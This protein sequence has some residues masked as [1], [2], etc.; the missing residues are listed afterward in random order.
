M[1]ALK[2]RAL[3]VAGVVA[4]CS[5]SPIGGDAGVDGGADAGTAAD[6]AGPS[7]DGGLGWSPLARQHCRPD[8]GCP[9]ELEPLVLGRGPEA[10]TFSVASGALP[11]GL[12]LD[13]VTGVVSGSALAEGTFTAGV[14]VEDGVRAPAVTEVTWA[15][16]GTG[17]NAP[18]GLTASNLTSTGVRLTWSVT[19]VGAGVH[20]CRVLQDG[21]RVTYVEGAAVYDVTGLAPATAYDFAVR[22]YDF[23]QNAGAVSPTLTVTTLSASPG[24]GGVP[25]APF[26]PPAPQPFTQCTWFVGPMG[27]DGNSGDSTA[28]AWRTLGRANQAV[29]PGQSV[30]VRGGTYD[31]TIRPA[32]SGTAGQPITYAAYNLETVT[33]R[34]SAASAADLGGR[35]YVT[36]RQLRLNADKPGQNEPAVAASNSTGVQLLECE[37]VN[38]R[39]MLM[40]MA[41][42]WRNPWGV[43][44]ANASAFRIEG[45]RV[46]G[47]HQGVTISNSPRAVVRHNAIVDNMGNAVLSAEASGAVLGQLIEGNLLGGS[48]TSDGV[49]TDDYGASQQT[50][51]NVRGLVIRGNVIYFNAENG[52]DLKAAGDVV[53]EDNLIVAAMGDND[54][55]GF[56]PDDLWWLSR[57][58]TASVIHGSLRTA[59][60]VIIRRNVFYDGSGGVS[61]MKAGWHVFNNTFVNGNR[62]F[63]SANSTWVGE[64]PTF[65]ALVAPG[66]D[67]DFF[68]NVVMNHRHGAIWYWGGVAG[69]VW[70]HNVYFESQGAPRFIVRPPGADRSTAAQQFI[71]FAAFRAQLPAGFVGRDANS[72]IANPL[73]VNVPAQPVFPFA[74]PNPNAPVVAPRVDFA[75]ASTMFPHDFR[76][77]A[78][79]PA[80]DTGRHLTT[81]TNAATGGTSLRVE[82]SGYFFAGYGVV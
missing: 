45:C 21:V 65:T 78:A 40:T 18:S 52:I 75:N 30:C 39:P 63:T 7:A 61:Q 9:L 73:F 55:H 56:R 25:S 59:G 14:H 26:G 76:L 11:V 77:Q 34:G 35:Q 22:C 5:A 23:A 50:A 1:R 37:V 67:S 64:E 28:A 57:S 20:G 27:D 29:Q 17:P 51:I 4:A 80:A 8:A 32:A 46:S 41:D 15:I 54:G 12:A 47:W 24:D 43:I 19:D 62:D 13:G 2:A 72:R 82:R 69:T 58:A 36:L 48:L 16:D 10:L 49:Q 74:Q 31:E 33:V 53:I 60:R 42:Y 44:A 70:D 68:N 3:V 38:P 66:N 81:T 6:D 79:S 71:E